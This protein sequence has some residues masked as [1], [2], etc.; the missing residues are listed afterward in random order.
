MVQ[1]LLPEFL[2]RALFLFEDDCALVATLDVSVEF[3]LLLRAFALLVP[4]ELEVPLDDALF[5][6]EPLSDVVTAC[7]WEP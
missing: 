1:L 6:A 2:E 7:I 4:F 3:D 5:D